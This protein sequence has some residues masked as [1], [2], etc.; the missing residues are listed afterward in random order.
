M[1]QWNK[2]DCGR[3]DIDHSYPVC[4]VR[5]SVDF[6][7]REMVALQFRLRKSGDQGGRENTHMLKNVHS[8][9]RLGKSLLSLSYPV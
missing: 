3:D 1:I 8:S 6:G 2:R 4:T 9:T 5:H 7:R